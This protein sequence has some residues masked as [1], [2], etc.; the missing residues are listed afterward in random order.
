MKIKKFLVNFLIFL[1]KTLAIVK[2]IFVAIFY[3]VGKPFYIFFRIIFYKFLVK[4]YCSYI[5]ILKKIGWYKFKG[6]FISFLIN[7][8]T[9]HFVVVGLTLV[10]VLMNLITDTQ[11]V[12]ASE[13]AQK[14]MMSKLISSEFGDNGRGEELTEKTVVDSSLNYN[15]DQRYLNDRAALKNQGGVDI[16]ADQQSQVN[17]FA[18]Q[19]I[20]EQEVIANSEISPSD[21][22]QDLEQQQ[23]QR[24]EVITY[25]VKSG[26]TISTIASNFGISVNTI[27]WENNL[28]AYDLIRP[29]DDLRILPTSGV[30][31]KISSG[32]TLS[33]VS[34]KYDISEDK[35]VKANNIKEAGSL[36]IGQELII[37]GGEKTTTKDNS[38]T[39]ASQEKSNRGISVLSDIVKSNDKKQVASNKMAWPTQGHRITQ[40]YSWRHHGLDIANNVG[41]PIYSSDAG[42]VQYARWSNGYGN[43]IVVNHGGGKQ[44]RYAHL[45]KFYCSKGDRIAKGENIGAMGSTG[46]STGPHVHFEV[47]INGKRYNPLN[48]IR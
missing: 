48:Y 44:T 7:Y 35:I 41:T 38:G 28:S 10:M 40:Y 34:N 13:Q 12:S 36:Q 37:P 3:I 2:N 16:E 8:R 19:M 6:N 39:T 11:M 20:P 45:S 42:T 9:V 43:N 18:G 30:I 5:S 31:H 4:I 32:E 23:T 14:T 1:F 33:Y 24:D 21:S 15:I 46:W 27:L 22:D 25:T 29:G 26:D 47:I 17:E